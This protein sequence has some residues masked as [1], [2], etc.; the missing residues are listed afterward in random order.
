MSVSQSLRDS[1]KKDR[2]KAFVDE[3][4]A[5]TVCAH[6]G[7]QPIQWHNP[8][9]VELNRKNFRIS[10]MAVI[11]RSTE[12]IEAEMARCTPLCRR[13][14][15]AEDGRT[16]THIARFGRK[17]KDCDECGTPSLRR[18][19]GLC[20]RCYQRLRRPSRNRPA[21]KAEVL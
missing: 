18:V 4:N 1:T 10:T 12:E 14:H 11:G 21:R 9:H 13:C 17:L 3:V 20:P 2:A 16:A 5:R 8:E 6:C 15:M 7:A 19:R